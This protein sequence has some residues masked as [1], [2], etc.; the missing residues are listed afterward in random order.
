MRAGSLH[1]MIGRM[2][3]VLTTTAQ[4]PGGV[5]RHVIDLG[6]GLRALGL[7][8]VIGG[9]AG[10]GELRRRADQAQL[11]FLP[12]R[13]AVL[14]SADVWHLHLHDTFERRGLEL[15][16]ARRAASRAG[17]AVVLTEHLP[18]TNASDPSLLDGRRRPGALAVKWLLKRLEVAGVDRV[19]ALS[20]G[21]RRF[22]A[23][24]YGLDAP[25]VHMV[26]NGITAPAAPAPLA[27]GG[28]LRIVA[29]GALIV[30][31]GYDV[32]IEAARSAR[33]PWAATVIGEGPGRPALER[34]AERDAPGRVTFA[35][36]RDDPLTAMRQA[37]LLCMPSRWESCPYAALEAMG[38]GRPVI[39]SAVDGLDEIVVHEQ[40]GLLVTPEDPPQL[41][42][43]LD[44]FAAR[45]SDCERLGRPAHERVAALYTIE[46]MARETAA[47]YEDARRP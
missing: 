37:H 26:R 13:Q 23:Q 38:L 31:K 20:D 24:R 44:R 18:R 14:A 28:E 36:W 5:W 39:A 33:R 47:V 46:R 12:L 43:A 10:A 35:G 40:T 8:A 32:L 30:Q 34:Q 27:R 7:D 22:L 16:V 41:A 6:Q 21:S 17:G 42:D 25:L 45:R 9:P 19:I 4:R 2:R 3:V 29:V 11:P 15:I 1:A